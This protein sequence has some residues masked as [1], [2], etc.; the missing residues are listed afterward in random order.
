MVTDI[1]GKPYNRTLLIATLILGAFTAILTSTMLATANAAI[2]KS[3]DI[4]TSTVQW[5]TTSFLLTNGIMIPVS[6]YLIN[7][8]SN[9]F[10]FEAAMMS[11]L[12][13][14]VICYVA[15]SFNI[16]L[17]GRI[18]QA[19]GVGI[20]MPLMQNVMLSIFPPEGRGTAM[21]IVGIAIGVAPAIG[22][23]LA[24]IIVDNWSWR[25][26]FGIVIPFSIIA[27]IA[28]F[29]FI[30]NVMKP[31]NPSLDFISVVTSVLG[32]GSLLYG[33]SYAGSN[34]WTD[35]TV[36]TT[37][38]VGIVVVGLFVW[39]QLK[40][41][42]PFLDMRVFT[43][44][45]YTIS[46]IISSIAYAAMTTIELVLPLYIQNVRGYSAF[47]SGLL[48]FPGAIMFAV[49]SPITGRLFDRYGAR[50][51]VLSGFAILTLGTLPFIFLTMHTSMLYV[52]VFYAIRMVGIT[53]MMM[54]MTTHAM[55]FIPREAMTHGTAVNNTARQIAGSLSTAVLTSVLTNVSSNAQPAKHLLH[56]NPLQYRDAAYNAV[57][58]GYSTA[59]V[60]IVILS[61]IGWLISFTLKKG[62]DAEILAQEK[63]AGANEW[64]SH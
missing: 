57:I 1:N 28:G 12:V 30:K 36:L 35:G 64:L 27:I 56:V 39:R 61:V 48:L 7:K 41:D 25:D 6:A 29:F 11:F 46:L 21:G 26:L 49:M 16:L 19:M 24:G 14:T 8:F 33:V 62:S 20:S 45:E 58:K 50:N 47:H 4:S 54:P 17:V 18:I 31:S 60:V 13:G 53:M 52:T 2:M 15:P 55:N 37:I 22:P 34:G 44:K 5:L 40:L 9:L 23:T 10:I 59:I 3:F 32:F 63:K 51:L 38:I 42:E 43:S